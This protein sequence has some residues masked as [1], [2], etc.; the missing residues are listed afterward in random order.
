MR[1]PRG[2]RDRRLVSWLV[3]GGGVEGDRMYAY[4][5]T[6]L[7]VLLDQVSVPTMLVMR[8]TTIEIRPDDGSQKD[9]EL[10]SRYV[11]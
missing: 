10:E 1:V 4:H 8:K 9:Y 3:V 6:L 11:E 2:G 5:S 7:P